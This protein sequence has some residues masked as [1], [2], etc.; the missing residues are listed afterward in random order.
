M[1][2]KD[3]SPKK[4]SEDR[5]IIVFAEVSSEDRHRGNESRLEYS[6]PGAIVR[7]TGRRR[8][9]IFAP[10]ALLVFMWIAALVLWLLHAFV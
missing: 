1:K 3:P 7:P 2:I 5:R 8:L 10:A 9:T 4:V 6:Q